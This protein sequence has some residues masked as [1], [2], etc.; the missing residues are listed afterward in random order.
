M[1]SE[2]FAMLL[3]LMASHLPES[4]PNPAVQ[5]EAARQPPA[6]VAR[7]PRLSTPEQRLAARKSV[8]REGRTPVLTTTRVMVADSR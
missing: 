3:L 6:V 7:V 8:P 5:A 2:Q 4:G 1:Y